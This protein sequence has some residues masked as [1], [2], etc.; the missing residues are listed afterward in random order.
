MNIAIIEDLDTDKAVLIKILEH[1]LL[2]EKTNYSIS[3]F[4]SGEA[5]LETFS[6]DKYQTVF[7][8]ILLDGGING[9]STAK[10]IRK[11]SKDIPIVFTTTEKSFA[12]ESYEVQA[13]DYLVKPYSE[14]RVSA[15]L[16]RIISTHNIKQYMTVKSGREDF[17]FCID[18]LM[19][20]LSL[21]NSIEIY[22][23]GGKNI[24]S[25]IPFGSICDDMPKQMRFSNPARGIIVNLDYVDYISGDDFILKNGVRIPI[26]RTKRQEMKRAFADYVISKTRTEVQL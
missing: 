3:H 14:E 25:Y 26:S 18:D 6:S 7:C 10:E 9:I 15:V 16:K 21:R 5:F 22:L 17:R 8:D 13:F 24:Q 4:Y 1:L 2:K 23:S 20:V 11:I 19:Y 12:L